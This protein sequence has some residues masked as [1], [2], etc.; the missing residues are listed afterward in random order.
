MF[1]NVKSEILPR[2]VGLV[3]LVTNVRLLAT[4]FPHMDVQVLFRLEPLDTLPHC[5]CEAIG[6][7]SLDLD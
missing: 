7:L 1:S 3:T 5:A 6:V 2:D 4:V